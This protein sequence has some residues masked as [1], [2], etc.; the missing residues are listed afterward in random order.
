ML[1]VAVGGVVRRGV[2]VGPVD[3]VGAFDSVGG[4][5]S[6]DGS[7][8]LFGREGEVGRRLPGV[9]VVVSGAAGRVA[10]VGGGSS[11]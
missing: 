5:V 8:S 11:G 1:V 6:V 10:A 4:A 7:G 3:L 2:P 9:G